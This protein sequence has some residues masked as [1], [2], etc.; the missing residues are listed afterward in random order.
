MSQK[1][2]AVENQETLKAV[3]DMYGVDVDE[4]WRAVNEGHVSPNMA[5]SVETWAMRTRIAADVTQ[6][7]RDALQ[8]IAA[9]E[10]LSWPELCW[11]LADGE[12]CV[13]SV[14]D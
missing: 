1:E 5:E 10:G 8:A 6:E 4:A 3:A 2:E 11:R 12:L 7:Q 13:K 14:D 9:A